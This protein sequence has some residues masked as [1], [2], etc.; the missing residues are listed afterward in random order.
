MDNT[1]NINKPSLKL[2]TLS[3][4]LTGILLG[5]SAYAGE[6]HGS[7]GS[8]GQTGVTI[9]GEKAT[10]AKNNVTAIGTKASSAGTYEVVIGSDA[11][12]KGDSAT[13]VGST[14]QAEEA[15]AS[16]FGDKSQAFGVSSTAIGTG[17][18]VEK[19]TISGSAFGATANVDKS[20]AVALGSASNTKKAATA[21][22]VSDTQT[23]RV[24]AKTFKNFAGVLKG[25]ADLIAGSQ[26]S[27]GGNAD[28]LFRQIKNVAA[29][30]VS[31][32]STDAVNGS[33]LWSGINYAKEDVT[34]ADNTIG[35]K[36]S[37]HT[38]GSNIFDLSLSIDD[39]TMKWIDDGNGGKKL[40]TKNAGGDKPITIDKDG[41]TGKIKVP[42]DDKKPATAKSV[43]EAIN[44]AGWRLTEKGKDNL[45]DLVTAGNTV[46]FDDGT[47]TTVSVETKDDVSTIKY[48]VTVDNK[49]TQI[50]GKDKDG[51]DIVKVGDKFFTV[52]KDGKPT[53]TE[54]A[55]ADVKNTAVS[56]KTGD[57][58]DADKAGLDGKVKANAGDENA[59][60]SVGNVVK[61]INSASHKITANNSDEQVG[62]KNG[63]K[64][65]KAGEE[66]I[67]EAG[68]NLN[69]KHD[70]RKFTFSTKAEVEFNKV[71]AK[72]GLTIG[73]GDK[74]TTMTPTTT[75]AL[76]KDGKQ[77]PNISAVD[78]GGSTFT[79]VAS[80][81]PKTTNK[82]GNAGTTAQQAPT[83][84]VGSNVATVDDVLN[85]GFN[86]Q[87]NGQAKDFVK[88]YDTVNFVNGTGTTAKVN[89]TD[90]KVSDVSYN[91]NVDEKTTQITGEDKDGNKIVKVGDKFFTTDKDGK[92]T[93]TEVAPNKVAKTQVVAKTTKL[94]ANDGSDAS[95]PK[96]TIATP[97]QPDSL[98]TAGTVANAINS[99]GFNV[100]TANGEVKNPNGFVK[101]GETVEINEGTNIKVVQDGKNFTIK[102]KA[103]VKFDNVQVG[104]VNINK[105]KGI[106][107][108][109]TKITNVAKGT[110]PTDAVNVSQ[111]KAIIGDTNNKFDVK[112]NQLA[113]DANAG[114]AS[115][116]AMAGLPQAFI[117][118][119]SM[120]VGATSYY[121][122]EG[123]VAIGLSKVSDNGRWVIKTGISADTGG[124]V[125]GTFGAG[126][127]F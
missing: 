73:E 11:I 10:Y 32:D 115:A 81:L 21:E 109:G 61:A 68:K 38:D 30:K 82:A 52:D 44:N 72:N 110:E 20:Y 117:A 114:T 60:A 15:N 70:G 108:G 47:G 77:K 101:M 26:V 13:A 83:G 97:A 48:S 22:T 96:G 39:A 8:I 71:L 33:Q 1:I 112:L 84:V 102:T 113:D 92:P 120:A 93:T 74:A 49:T 35:I 29:G 94:M 104:K 34:S 66:L 126:M 25:D 45:K 122:G 80:N 18:T 79:G 9:L 125:G 64:V 75:T 56:A 54:V 98:V 65:M 78:L 100:K 91:V 23:A 88:P 67:L 36:K 27:V 86:L 63:T 19:G 50:T 85:A 123:A 12:T 58:V 55:P 76:D 95:K 17:A 57:I 90:N 4:A 37:S 53:K 16:A 41:D 107:A 40:A 7:T 3:M 105:D 127:H 6:T 124:E 2:A 42:T 121:N 106:D 116:M 119:K 24:G 118:G 99:A 5:Q 31:G 111:L 51:N 69:V 87:N 43:A 14:A 28:L 62:A 46:N 59:V 103:D 89:V